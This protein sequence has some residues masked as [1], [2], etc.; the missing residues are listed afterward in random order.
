M[1]RLCLILLTSLALKDT[2]TTLTRVIFALC[3]LT[4]VPVSAD[5]EG[6]SGFQRDSAIYA[7]MDSTT[8]PATIS[9][10][11]ITRN[12][13]SRDAKADSER[14]ESRV[15]DWEKRFRDRDEKQSTKDLVA[16]VKCNRVII[17]EFQS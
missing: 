1:L 5:T 8:T 4:C 3:T 15:R 9:G 2:A 14:V 6:S 13:T 17:S 11:F 7:A 12:F 10:K 16:V